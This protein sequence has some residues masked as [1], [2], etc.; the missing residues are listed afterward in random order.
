MQTDVAEALSPGGA[1]E[2]PRRSRAAPIP[3]RAL[4]CW[5][6]RRG[7]PQL[8]GRPPPAMVQKPRAGLQQVARGMGATSGALPAGPRG[9]PADGGDDGRHRAWIHPDRGPEVLRRPTVEPGRADH[10]EASTA[11]LQPGCAS[12]RCARMS[13]SQGV[14]GERLGGGPRPGFHGEPALTPADLD[15][16]F[17]PAALSASRTRSWTARW[18]AAV[19]ID[20]HAARE[21]P[22]LSWHHED[23]PGF[24]DRTDRADG[25]TA[26]NMPSRPEARDAGVGVI[27]PSVMPPSGRRLAR[28][29]E[30][31]HRSVAPLP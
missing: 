20:A 3:W 31:A 28:P 15:V 22:A 2:G 12:T 19:R 17:D 10:D 5:R 7:G 4:S 24:E 18:K 14:G 11:D 6:R 16:L 9:P 23:V 26:P 8:G 29:G 21:N 27:V 30:A 13:R 25:S 1:V